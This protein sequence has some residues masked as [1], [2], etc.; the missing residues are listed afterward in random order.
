MVAPKIPHEGEMQENMLPMGSNSQKREHEEEGEDNI[1]ISNKQA[2]RVDYRYLDNPY[3]DEFDLSFTV[4]PS[5]EP[6]SLEEAKRSP[7]WPEWEKVIKIELD[8]L[9]DIRESIMSH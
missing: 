8:Q 6:E 7:E 3:A 5:G 4:S 9:T 2:K 1:K